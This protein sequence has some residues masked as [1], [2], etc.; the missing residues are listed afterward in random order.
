MLLQFISLF[1]FIAAGLVSLGIYFYNKRRAHALRIPKA[2]LVV[3]LFFIIVFGLILLPIFTF[4]LDDAIEISKWPSV[5]GTIT[6]SKVV[7]GR[8]FRPDIHYEYSVETKTFADTSTLNSPGF[9]G[10]MNRL[11]AAEKLVQL[12]PAG[13]TITVYYNP[14]NNAESTLSPHPTYSNYLKVGTSAFLMWIGMTILFT[15]GHFRPKKKP[16]YKERT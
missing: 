6:V 3:G 8:A 9:G 13:K 12:Y 15:Y 11:D 2:V 1:I 10:R 5:Q 16:I 14:E 4:Q 7:G